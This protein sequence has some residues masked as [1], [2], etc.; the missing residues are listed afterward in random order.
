MKNIGF[1]LAMCVTLCLTGCFTTDTAP[2]KGGG[3]HIMVNNYGV[4]FF[5]W[6]PLFCGNAADDPSCA[7]VM[8]R[9]DVTLEKVQHRFAVAANGRTLDRPSHDVKSAIFHSIFGLPIPYLFTYKE[10]TLSGTAK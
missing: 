8:F 6:I 9:D 5:N 4:K 3:E 7:F 1:V 10:I 2:V